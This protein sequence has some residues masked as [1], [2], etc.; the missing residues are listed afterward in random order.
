MKSRLQSYVSSIRFEIKMS[1]IHLV[2]FLFAPLLVFCGWFV[3]EFNI[4]LR[5]FVLLK[6]KTYLICISD[7]IWTCF[8]SRSIEVDYLCRT[9]H[10]FNVWFTLASLSWATSFVPKCLVVFSSSQHGLAFHSTTVHRDQRDSVLGSSQNSSPVPTLFRCLFESETK[11]A[12]NRATFAC[13]ENDS[14]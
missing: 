9:F 8:K 5:F 11:L 10:I 2:V 14:E 1:Q 13:R 3:P 12:L 7:G 6:N 4:V